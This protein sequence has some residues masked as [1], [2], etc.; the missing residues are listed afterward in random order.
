MRR[1]WLS[2][3][4]CASGAGICR[5]RG[6]PPLRLVWAMACVHIEMF[7]VFAFS[8]HES[9]HLTLL[10]LSVFFVAAHDVRSAMLDAC[11]GCTADNCAGA[12]TGWQEGPLFTSG[13]KFDCSSVISSYCDIS[14]GVLIV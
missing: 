13:A 4:A 9:S 11:S 14:T 3:V 5:W 8:L 12:V 10:V 6:L 1:C 2:T 7:L